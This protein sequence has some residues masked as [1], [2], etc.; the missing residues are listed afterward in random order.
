MRRCL[1][2][3]DYRAHL[4]ARAPELRCAAASTSEVVVLP[5]PMLAR[6]VD[7][8]NVSVVSGCKTVKVELP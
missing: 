8:T 2:R 4:R 7:F 6:N 3:P 5:S 1:T